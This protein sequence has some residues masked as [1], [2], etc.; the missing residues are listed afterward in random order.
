VGQEETVLARLRA[1]P[2][3][4]AADRNYRIRAQ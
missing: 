2:A 3:V 1:D 4:I